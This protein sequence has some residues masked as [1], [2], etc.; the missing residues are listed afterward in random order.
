MLLLCK[1]NNVTKRI[2]RPYFLQIIKVN[3]FRDP[4]LSGSTNIYLVTKAL[5]PMDLAG[6]AIFVYL[7]FYYL[8]VL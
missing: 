4:S 8:Y 7:S 5:V 2:F 6:L 1:P 3:Y